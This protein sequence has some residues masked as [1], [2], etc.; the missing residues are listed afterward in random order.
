MNEQKSLLTELS[1]AIDRYRAGRRA[2][3]GEQEVSPSRPSRLRRVLRWLMP[4]G[5]TLLLTAALLPILMSPGFSSL[6]VPR[7]LG[8]GT[9]G[10]AW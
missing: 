4:N 9:A 8:S 2:A 1:E 6:V 3:R 5:G 7:S 10:W